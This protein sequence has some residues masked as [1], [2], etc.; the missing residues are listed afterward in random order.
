MRYPA[1]QDPR[2]GP[3]T[4]RT[5][6]EDSGWIGDN[7][8]W[9][10]ADAEG[11]ALRALPRR[12]AQHFLAAQRG[13]RASVG[14][15]R[16]LE[17]H[18]E[19]PGLP[20]AGPSTP[21][22]AAKRQQETAQA[23]GKPVE[24]TLELGNG[25]TLKL[26]LIPAGRFLMGSDPAAGGDRDES[27]QHEV[28]ISKPFYLGSYAVTQ[29]QYVA[30]MG[31]GGVPTDVNGVP[32]ASPRS[33]MPATE[34]AW[35]EADEFC[36]KLSKQ[37]GRKVRLPRE[38]EWEYA[39]RAGT[40][41]PYPTGKTLTPAQANFAVAGKVQ[42]AVAVGTFP[43]NAW[44]LYDMTGNVCEWCADWYGEYSADAQCDP[45][46]PATG[47]ARVIR[48]GGWF[49]GPDACRSAAR[50]PEHTWYGR[51]NDLGFRVVVEID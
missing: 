49:T 48:G 9:F 37:L 22:E 44:E 47:T 21:S 43:P 34:V 25:I 7:G 40:A 6:R 50:R 32:A 13:V 29:T 51:I 5:Y 42:Q 33:T 1:E 12:S 41:T 30:V 31:K 2:H 8:S 4:L 17:A 27:P 14:R 11:H 39:C 26:T 28:I 46:G 35:Y 16:H 10:S 3:V 20:R 36:Q 19:K 15:F 18:R 45:T 23:L 24:S 38:A